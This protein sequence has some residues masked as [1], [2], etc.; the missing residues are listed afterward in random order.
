MLPLNVTLSYYKKREIQEEI[1]YN[2]IDREI[3]ARYNDKFGQRPDVLN[4][5][6][7]V[8]ELVKQGASSFH[9]SEELWISP[10]RLN[11]AMKRRELDELR[12]GWD[13][14]LDIDCPYWE[15]SKIITWL[16][17]KA[18]RAFNIKSISIK[19]S[20]NKGFHIGIPFEAFPEEI[21]GEETK[22]KFPE[23][24]KAIAS[25]LLDY[26]SENLIEVTKDNK[27]SFGKRFKISFENLRK[28]TSK[29]IEELTKKYCS[30]CNGEIKEIK[31]VSVEFI[32]PKCG[33]SIKDE[34]ADFLKCDKCKIFMEKIVNKPKLCRCGS[35]SFKRKF[36]PLSI[37][38]ID[39]LLISSRHMYRMPYSL[40]EKSG[41]YSRPFNPD[42]VLNFEKKYADPSNAKISKWRF[43]DRGCA[44]KGEMRELCIKSLDFID[45]LQ[46]QKSKKD[47]KEIKFEDIDKIPETLF[48][49]CMKN[50]FKGLKDGRKRCL[51]AMVNF[52]TCCGWGY[53]DIEEYLTEW[54]KN[55]EE[56]LREVN[57]KGQ[58]R[59]HKANKK[60]IMP[61][62]CSNKMY[63]KDLGVCTSDNLCSKIKNPVNYAL[64]KGRFLNKSKKAKKQ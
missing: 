39:T 24:P 12:K 17:V 58:I 31:K 62:N 30:E 57:I 50:I 2:A 18:L 1:V 25:Y 11:T 20:G 54:N 40:H 10:L 49:P 23:L 22:N 41:L 59:Y 43:L 42:K 6:T 14:I 44:L 56:P 64:R 29:P 45:N 21:K 13:F 34:E 63:Y 27:I 16:I 26:I 15:L 5:A 38:E 28:I 35:S 19:F 4:H 60:K 47:I 33:Y 8:L 3:A 32:C 51:F 7:D 37:I 48:P 53:S 46:I 52:L 36:N 55:N 9:A 61:P